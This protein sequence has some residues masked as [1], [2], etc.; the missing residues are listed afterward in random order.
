MDRADLYKNTG[1]PFSMVL[2]PTINGFQYVINAK[3]CSG[4]VEYDAVSFVLNERDFTNYH[5]QLEGGDQN[6]DCAMIA[7]IYGALV[8][9]TF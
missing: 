5:I 1:K 9:S 8:W 6:I 3:Y 7:Q 2:K 4:N